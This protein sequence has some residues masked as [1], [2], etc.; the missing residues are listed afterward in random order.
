MDHLKDLKDSEKFESWLGAI[1]KNEAN[2]HLRTC[3]TGDILAVEF[4]DESLPAAEIVNYYQSRDAAID[5]DR[6]LRY[7][8]NIS[9]SFGVVFR[10]YIGEQLDFDQIA[11]RLGENKE[12]IRTQYYRGFRKL[13][14]KF[15][16]SKT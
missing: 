2:R 5:V 6:M 1:S 3:I 10:L 11:E 7:A 13:K 12:K 8:D 14:D 15:N 16:E 9:E 4:T